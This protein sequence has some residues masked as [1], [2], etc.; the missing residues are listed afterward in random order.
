LP[1]LTTPEAR[2]ISLQYIPEAAAEIAEAEKKHPVRIEHWADAIEDY[3]ETAALVLALDVVISVCTS[4]VHLSGSLGQ[5][6]WVMAPYSPEWRYGFSGESMPWY[7]SVRM[8]RQPAFGEWD[9]VISS[10]AVELG[11]L[12]RATGGDA[13]D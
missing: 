10:V 9:P 4:I 8:F 5:R 2:F 13:K 3:E 6:V 12:A 11:R 7:P 1:V